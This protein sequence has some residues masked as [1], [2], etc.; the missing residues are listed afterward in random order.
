MAD[1]EIAALRALLAQR[2]RPP[3]VADRRLA[4]DQFAKIFP[5]A[6]DIKV[7]SVVANGVPA[8]WTSAQG[9]DPAQ[10]VDGDHRATSRHRSQ[11]RA[12]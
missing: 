11:R 9:A 8:E 12:A 2:P 5:T 1:P 6:G 4:F 7:E 3:E 10:A